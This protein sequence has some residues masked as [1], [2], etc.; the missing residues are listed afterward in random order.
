MH[1]HEIVF[2]L[3]SFLWDSLHKQDHERGSVIYPFCT[4]CLNLLIVTGRRAFLLI[5][6]Y[7]LVWLVTSIL[8]SVKHLSCSFF[9]KIAAFGLTV[10]TKSLITDI[11]KYTNQFW[12]F[13]N[14]LFNKNTLIFQASI[15][16]K[17]FYPVFNKDSN[18]QKWRNL[19]RQNLE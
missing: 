1:A 16:L 3:R 11:L 5:Y 9:A 19:S 14:V 15:F 7:W 4:Y 6:S 18:W 2:T 10:F 13:T 8:G 12:H 17:V